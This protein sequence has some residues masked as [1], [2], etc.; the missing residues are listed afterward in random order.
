MITNYATLQAALAGWL[1]RADLTDRIQE[2]IQ[3][4]EA[5]FNRDLRVSEMQTTLQGTVSS[6]QIQLPADCR[7]VQ[8]VRVAIGSYYQEI[9]PLPAEYLADTVPTMG[10]PF[11]YVHVDGILNLVGGTGSQA[12]KVTYFQRIPALDSTNTTNW[13]LTREPGLY[14]Y[15][16]L[17]EASPYLKDDERTL[18]WAQQYQSIL[19]GMQGEDDEVRFGNAPRMQPPMRMAP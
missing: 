3:L 10:F 15:G 9:E 14:L 2:F 11:G 13:L 7:R 6:G 5:R 12:F 18:V 4:A 16:S 1:A 19:S 17:I 8:S